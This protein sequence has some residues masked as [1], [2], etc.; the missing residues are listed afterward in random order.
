MDLQKTVLGLELGSTRIKAVLIDEK[1]TPVASGDHD[2]VVLDCG[3]TVAPVIF[4]IVIS[5]S[6]VVIGLVHTT[7]VV[8][9]VDRGVEPIELDFFGHIE[10][11]IL[12]RTIRSKNTIFERLEVRS[13]LNQLTILVIGD[14]TIREEVQVAGCEQYSRHRNSADIQY[15]LFHSKHTKVQNTASKIKIL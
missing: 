15:S 14:S 13:R 1:G 4:H 6:E 3:I 9:K 11:T 7:V 5:S 8:A 2:V 12:V 10:L